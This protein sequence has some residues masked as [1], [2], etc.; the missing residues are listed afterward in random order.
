MF[1]IELININF[2]LRLLYDKKLS[3]ECVDVRQAVA[4]EMRWG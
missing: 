2:L 3:I 4:I 1:N